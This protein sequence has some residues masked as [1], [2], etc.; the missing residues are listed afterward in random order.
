MSTIFAKII[1]GEAPADIVYRDELVTAF[2][3]IAPV[4]PT[5][6]LVVPNKEIATTNDIADEDGPLIGHMVLIAKR[7]AAEEGIAENGYRLLINCNRDAGQEVFHLHLHLLGGRPLGPMLA[8][9]GGG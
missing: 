7:L 5:H 2:R 8:R 4:A 9:S 6:I 1:A 3:D